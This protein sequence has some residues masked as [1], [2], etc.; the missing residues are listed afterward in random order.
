MSML[1]SL[2]LDWEVVDSHAVTPVQVLFKADGV[3]P[4]ESRGLP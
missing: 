3:Y 4:P 1:H 2:L